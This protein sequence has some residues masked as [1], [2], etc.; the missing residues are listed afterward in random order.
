MSDLELAD[1]ISHL[2]NEILDQL[3]Q[4]LRAYMVVMATMHP[5][6]GYDTDDLLQEMRF[7][8]WD[9]IR[10]GKFDPNKSKPITYFSWVFRTTLYNLNQYHHRQC[11]IDAYNFSDSIDALTE[12]LEQETKHL[13]HTPQMVF[14]DLCSG[15]V[16]PH[17][18][19]NIFTR[20]STDP[21]LVCATCMGEIRRIEQDNQQYT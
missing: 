6:P 15:L 2:E 10:Q 3:D 21:T 13:A 5:V 17:S 7:K 18:K 8:M 16:D 12:D 1:S 14:C 11:R 4:H 9:K 19:W 20:R